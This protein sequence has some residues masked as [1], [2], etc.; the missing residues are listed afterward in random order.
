MNG[1]QSYVCGFLFSHDLLSVKL[2]KKNRPKW[3]AGRHN[4]IGG[5]IEEGETPEQAMVREFTEETGVDFTRWEHFCVLGDATE[6]FRVWFYT[7]HATRDEFEAVRS[8]TDEE[9]VSTIWS[10]SQLP[11]ISNL[12]FL[13]PMAHYVLD[14]KQKLSARISELPQ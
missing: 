13:I 1:M 6:S 4:G 7:G 8:T 12:R 10:V 9:V 3:Q 5:H 11:M 14:S 2:I